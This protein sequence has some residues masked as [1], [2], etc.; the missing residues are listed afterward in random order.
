MSDSVFVTQSVAGGNTNVDV[1]SITQTGGAQANRQR[2]R[3]GGANANDLANVF[4]SGGLQVGYDNEILSSQN[5]TTASGA[6]ANTSA[7]LANATYVT[8]STVILQTSEDHTSIQLQIS[9]S[10]T[11]TL[12]TERTLDGTYWFPTNVRRNAAGNQI[13]NLITQNGLYAGT[14]AGTHSYRIRAL[15]GFTGTATITLSAGV[16]SGTYLISEVTTLSQQQYYA[17]S[18]GMNSMWGLCSQEVALATS[19]TEYP[20]LFLWNNDAVGGRVLYLAKTQKTASS[21]C[22]IRRYRTGPGG[23]NMTRTSGGNAITINN[24]ANQAATTTAALAWGGPGIVIA[25]QPSQYEKMSFIGQSGNNNGFAIE[26]D[27]GGSILV[28]P[29]TG[30]LWTGIPLSANQIASVEVV[31]WDGLSLP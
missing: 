4:S 18:A 29:Q 28:P 24:R 25:N 12:Q 11:G 22:K 10:W 1:E 8:G 26:T 19:G 3:L 21:A 6:A 7:G 13:S 5:I 30:L 27:E 16:I 20:L 9:G 15:T 17:S 31:Y 23:T 14:Y 2:V